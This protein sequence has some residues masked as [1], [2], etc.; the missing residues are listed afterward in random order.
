MISLLFLHVAALLGM[1]GVLL[2]LRGF[3]VDRWVYV[4]A[5]YFLVRALDRVWSSLSG[6]PFVNAPFVDVLIEL[7]LLGAVFTMVMGVR[8]A[9]RAM[10]TTLQSAAQRER[11]YADARD[12]YEAIMRHRIANPL[13]T[14]V[15]GL[16]TIR[17]LPLAPDVRDALFQAMI[18]KSHELSEIS[19]Q[20]DPV[21]MVE[22]A[23]DRNGSTHR[24]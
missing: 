17:D 8:T 3:G 21:D 1:V 12:Y 6:P 16:H 13:T 23:I 5:F 14:I 24:E 19:L 18:D 10:H 15:G 9:H 2:L 7:V 20:P 22:A 11:D 4:A